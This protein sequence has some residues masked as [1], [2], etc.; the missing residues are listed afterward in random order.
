MCAGRDGGRA[1][2]VRHVTTDPPQIWLDLDAASTFDTF[3]VPE[4]G[5]GSRRKQDMAKWRHEKRRYKQYKVRKEQLPASYREAIDAVERYALRF[6]PAT[7]ETVVGMLEDLAEIFEQ[8]ANDGTPVREI[9][10]DDPVRFTEDFLTR[11]PTPWTGRD[12]Q[13]LAHAIDAAE[14]AGA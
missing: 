6:G 9:V 10:G 11:Y 13:R 14:R 1:A 7:G 5:H 4:A 3:V 12:Q 8:G 2:T